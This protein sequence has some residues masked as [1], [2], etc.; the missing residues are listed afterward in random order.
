[1]LLLTLYLGTR[2]FLSQ[3]H[4]I[5]TGYKSFYIRT[6]SNYDYQ[7]VEIVEMEK[8]KKERDRRKNVPSRVCV[9]FHSGGDLKMYFHI[10][11]IHPFW[12]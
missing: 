12:L 7:A 6:G 10:H 5:S 2:S 3:A 1:M 4:L 8:K 9:I 11:F